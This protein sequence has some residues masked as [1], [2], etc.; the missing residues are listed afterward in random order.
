MKVIRSTSI[1]YKEPF[2]IEK[3]YR[4]FKKIRSCRSNLFLSK[5]GL[6]INVK[7]FASLVSFFLML[8]KGDSFLLIFEG[9]DADQALES[10]SYL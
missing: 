9:A 2:T 7:T 1:T 8:K 10:L 6:L 5:Q 3:I 4:F